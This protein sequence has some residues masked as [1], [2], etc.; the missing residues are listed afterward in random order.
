M[1]AIDEELQRWTRGGIIDE[2][3]AER[4]RLFEVSRQHPTG[5]RWQVLL[6]LIFGAILLA[7]G[8]TLFVAAHWDELSP[9]ARFAVVIGMLAVLHVG[10]LLSRP[11]FDWLAITLH[12]V[13]TVAA[14]AAV[15]LVGQIF[16]IQK[17]WPEGVLLWAL[18][19]LAGWA[20]L[21]DQVQQTISMFLIPARIICEWTARTDGYRGSEVFLARMVTVF[22]AVYLTCFLH[23]KKKLV[24][25]LL[26]G[27]ASIALVVGTA[28]LIEFRGE[29][30]NWEKNQT[31]PRSLLLL[32]WF[33]IAVLPLVVSRILD[34][35]A[36]LPVGLI[37][38]TAIILPHLYRLSDR[39]YAMTWLY[40]TPTLVAHALVALV[41]A[42][43]TW[44]GVQQRSRALINYGV[45]CFAIAVLW[46]YFSSVMG[47]LERS[48]SLMMLGI[49]FLAG[50]WALE[51]TRR[52]LVRGIEEGDV[53]PRTRAIALLVIQCVL[54][55]S[56]AAKYLY[57][58][59]TCPRVWV[60]VAQYDP[61]LPMRGRY[62]SLSPIVDA[63]DLPHDQ[64]SANRF[65]DKDGHQKI[66]N[67]HW[68]VRTVARDGK[69]AVVDARDFHP[70][71]ATQYLWP[72][73]DASC[74]HARFAAVDL[75]IADMAKDPFPLKKGQEL[76]AEVTEPPAGPP[77]PIQ[78]AISSSGEWRPSAN[79][80]TSAE[81]RPRFT[82]GPALR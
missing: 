29:W 26:F 49:L 77:R 8:V 47:K 68:R 62:L 40:P 18:C 4:I 31:M 15:A 74:D 59:K 13:G 3:T 54:V 24:F 70:R 21:R 81:K 42:F 56:I 76:W 20:L 66:Y 57:E 44:W 65:P 5:L 60:V 78:L 55:S 19:A 73:G 23:S 46:F 28:L 38:A 14:G 63:C 58:P 36:V 61:N 16:N 67:W 33:C 53:N 37:L 27:A 22:A 10:G 25:G 45:V 75:F 32:G 71:S 72:H 41:A 43:L 12:G 82:S 69:L 51:K 80:L 2:S 11:H 34:R 7:S 17:H 64:E 6:A 1:S 48:F 39:T 35:S 30:Y 50:G 9:A 52:K 79:E